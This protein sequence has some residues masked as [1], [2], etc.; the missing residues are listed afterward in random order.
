MARFRIG[1]ALIVVL[2]LVTTMGVKAGTKSVYPVVVFRNTTEM[3]ASG[4]A[5]SAR[6]NS[7]SPNDIGCYV[8]VTVVR[9][10]PPDTVAGGI[11]FVVCSAQ[12]LTD[13][14]YCT[15]QDAGIVKLAAMINSDSYISFVAHQVTGVPDP[16]NGK[17]KSLEVQTYGQF[18]PKVP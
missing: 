11:P 2:T 10:S 5:G 9:M 3:G 18:E 1:G 12:G 6:S 13:T 15:S 17:C 14:A 8:G 16:D 4:A 7:G